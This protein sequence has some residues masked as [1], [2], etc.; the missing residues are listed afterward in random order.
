MQAE[1]DS[2]EEDKKSISNI[3]VEGS[4]EVEYKTKNGRDYAYV[5]VSY[6]M[7]GFFQ[8]LGHNHFYF[9]KLLLFPAVLLCQV[10]VIAQAQGSADNHNYN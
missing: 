8:I 4:K 10:I 3:T 5:D 6:F 1:V 7:I 9:R 2:F